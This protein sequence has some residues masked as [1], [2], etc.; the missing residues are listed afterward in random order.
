MERSSHSEHTK[1]DKGVVTCKGFK[2][3]LH[4]PSTVKAYNSCLNTP[5][6]RLLR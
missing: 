2:V 4:N 1:K 5:K 6:N 3:T